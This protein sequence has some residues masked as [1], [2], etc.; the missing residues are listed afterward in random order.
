MT[1]AKP[2][3]TP[4]PANSSLT[5]VGTP[6]SNATLY[7]QTVGALQY[8]TITRPDQSYAVNKV[9]QFMYTPTTDHWNAVKQILWYAKATI[10]HGLLLKHNSS[11][12]LH[13]YFDADWAGCP[14]DHK[15]TGAYAIFL[16][17]NLIA[18]SSKKQ[19]TVA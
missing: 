19:P 15:S 6:F 3:S 17:R 9:C 5:K 11:T 2:I 12:H 7:H 1:G 18:W 8:L 10:H 13:D 14:D 4:L 16:G